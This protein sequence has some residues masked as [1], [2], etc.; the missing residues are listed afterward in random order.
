MLN[1]LT[2]SRLTLTYCPSNRYRK[3]GGSLSHLVGNEAGRFYSCRVVASAPALRQFTGLLYQSLMTDNEDCWVIGGMTD[4]Q[5]KQK[6]SK[7]T[8]S[9]IALTTTDPKFDLP[10][11]RTRAYAVG[12]RRLT[13]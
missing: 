1:T 7:K 8:C 13:A 12:S 9:S 10:Q 5:G 4:R 3:N 11:F 2:K 6:Y